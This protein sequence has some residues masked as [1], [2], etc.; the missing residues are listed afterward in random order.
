MVCHE[1][2]KDQN[3]KWLTQRKSRKALME[4]IKISDK[5]EVRVGAFGSMSKSKKMKLTQK[6]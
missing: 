4:N 6:I 2:Y 5:S 3:G 1:T